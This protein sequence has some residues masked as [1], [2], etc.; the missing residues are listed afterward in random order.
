MHFIIDTARVVEVFCFIDDFCK[1]VEDYFTSHPLPKGLLE[2]HPAGRK[3]SLSE[4]EVLTILVLYHLSGFKCFE[5]Y[6]RRLVL[7]ELRSFF[8]RAVS[9]TQ[10]LSLARQACFH[11]FL[12]AQCRCS[13]SARTGHYYIDSKKLPVCD[14]LRI[15]SHRVF[16]GIASRG[17][18][19]TGWFFGLKLH[20][21]IN[22]HGELARLLITP[23]NVADNNHQVLGRLLEGLKGKC[24][25]DRGYLSSLLGELL[26]KGLHLVAK[27]R[28]NMKNML[29]TL[30]DKL[31]LMK[32]GG[33]EAVN[34]ILMSVCDIDHT[35]H[36][37]PLNALVHILSGLTAYTFLDHKNKR[38]NPAR[39]LA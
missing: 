36:R 34:D 31:N 11:A 25:G 8:P 22:Q 24:Y 20:L 27:I 29:L 14:N 13:L 12:L 5:Y 6:Y 37:N 26:E 35:R 7:G 15:H 38:F 30:S 32:R 28:K 17:K 3:P 4:S 10:F 16:E 9:Y 19:S 23:A 33:I 2:K 21:V 1:E 39:T 18:G